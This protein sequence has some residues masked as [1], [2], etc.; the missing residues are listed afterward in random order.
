MAKK[1]HSYILRKI[2]QNVKL[3]YHSSHSHHRSFFMTLFS[4]ALESVTIYNNLSVAQIK[5][6]PSALDLMV[7]T[8]LLS[9]NLS[10]CARSNHFYFV[11]FFVENQRKFIQVANFFRE[12]VAAKSTH[13]EL[14]CCYVEDYL[15][16]SE[17]QH[18]F[19]CIARKN[20]NWCDFT[21]R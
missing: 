21:Q 18:N 16:L 9:D 3:F 5:E 15:V 13:N 10:L 1:N 14:A 17:F 6:W 4:E 8:F 2:V 11:Y 12:N 20:K 7:R 19:V